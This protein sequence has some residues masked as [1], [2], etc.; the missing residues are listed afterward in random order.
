MSDAMAE[1]RRA[2]SRMQS[3]RDRA[4]QRERPDAAP[5]RRPDGTDDELR[6]I[7]DGRLL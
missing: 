7:D 2:R 6:Q 1:F 3:Q 5:L 4:H